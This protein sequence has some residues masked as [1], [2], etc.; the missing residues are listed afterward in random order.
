M[1]AMECFYEVIQLLLY[2]IIVYI[3]IY[4][5]GSYGLFLFGK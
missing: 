3:T 2:R 4:L 5:I 1:E